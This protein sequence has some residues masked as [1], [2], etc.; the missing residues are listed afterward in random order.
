[1]RLTRQREL[2]GRGAAD[3]T[4]LLEAVDHEGRENA[5]NEHGERSEENDQPPHGGSG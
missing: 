1:V 2:G 3:V 4:A 5:R